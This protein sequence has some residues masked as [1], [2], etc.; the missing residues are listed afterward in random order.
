MDCISA[1]TSNFTCDKT[2][3]SNLETAIHLCDISYKEPNDINS[4]AIYISHAITDTQCYI[5]CKDT[6]LF[7]CFRG[8]SSLKDVKTDLDISLLDIKIGSVNCKVHLGFYKQYISISDV[9]FE[10]ILQNLH[11]NELII[12]GHSLGGALAT[13]ATLDLIHKLPNCNI[14]CITFGSPRVGNIDFVN[15]YNEKIQKS[16]RIVNHKD[17]I[18]Y[19]PLHHLY[20]HVHPSICFKKRE[21]VIKDKIHWCIRIFNLIKNVD[22]LNPIKYHRTQYYVKKLALLK[23]YIT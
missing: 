6:S 19:F 20:Y 2:L 13:L 9:L 14:K 3:C 15:L 1:K 11:F 12:C 21:V 16:Y 22:W 5:F 18:Q 4:Q 17:P 8:T 10:H 23:S 7:V